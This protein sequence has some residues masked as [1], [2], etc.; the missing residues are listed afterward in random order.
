MK[1]IKDFSVTINRF[2][3]K[4]SDIFHSGQSCPARPE[5]TDA[6]TSLPVGSHPPPAMSGCALPPRLASRR[7]SAAL[8][9]CWRAVQHMQSHSVAPDRRPAFYYYERTSGDGW[10]RGERLDCF[11]FGS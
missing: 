8:D 9:R 1:K 10:E 2:F 3:F 5:I 4:F 7:G 6:L 11:V